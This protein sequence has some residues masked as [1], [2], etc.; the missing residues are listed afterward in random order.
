MK[1]T[2]VIQLLRAGY[3]KAEIDELRNQETSSAIGTAESIVLPSSGDSAEKAVDTGFPLSA[4]SPEQNNAE[5]AELKQ[6]VS[7]LQKLVQ[8][9]N[10]Q[11][12]E[13]K[14]V[15]PESAVDILASI[16]NPPKKEK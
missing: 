5:I 6:M 14:P 15:A 3:T 11:Q 13:L 12:S 10:I 9:Q 4:E 2:E 1:I 8:K 7:N 16:I